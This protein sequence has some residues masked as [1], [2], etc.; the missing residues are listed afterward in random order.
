[1][2]ADRPLIIWD[3]DGTLAYREGGMWSAT[4]AEVVNASGYCT[5]QLL[6]SD[7]TPYLSQ[8]FPWHQPFAP[9]TH[10][11]DPDHWWAEL[12]TVFEQAIYKATG[13]GTID[14]SRLLPQIRRLY[15]DP[16]HWRVFP[17]V[18]PCLHA[19]SADGWSHQILSNHVPELESLVGAL[20]IKHHFD[21]VWT[22]ASLGYEKP[23]P[24]AYT[25]ALGGSPAA[26]SWMIGD[27]IQADVLGAAKHG[28]RAVLVRSK[29]DQVP[30]SMLD[31]T[32]LPELLRIESQMISTN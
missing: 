16:S 6:P 9:H 32:P 8:G 30:F 3:F 20:G 23:H 27:S 25:A 18:V 7:F 19:L 28:L 14:M 22:S 1:M 31:L 2:K 29:S 24:A 5:R 12:G 10:I 21:A 26:A 4:L 11:T 13:T 17:D 15:I